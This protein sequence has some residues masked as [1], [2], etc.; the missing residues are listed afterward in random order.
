MFL[1][2]INM[3][4]SEARALMPRIGSKDCSDILEEIYKQIKDAAMRNCENLIVYEDDLAE[5]IGQGGSVF[6]PFLEYACKYLEE[7]DGFSIDCS[8]VFAGSC[9]RRILISW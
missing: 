1:R 6:L 8:Y 5:S 9:A 4:A 2:Y 3:K 7:E